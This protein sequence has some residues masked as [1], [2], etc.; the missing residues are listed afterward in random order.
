MNCTFNPGDIQGNILRGYKFGRVRHLLLEVGDRTSA[1]AFLGA[2]AAGGSADVPAITTESGERWRR[3]PGGRKPDAC[4]NLGLTSD[5]LKALG[6]SAA[7]LASFPTEFV[8]GMAQRAEKL[9]DFGDSAPERWAAPFDRQDRIHLVA[10]IHADDATRIDRIQAQVARAFTVLGALDGQTLAENRVF[11]GYIDSI[12]Q[13]RFIGI[14]DPDQADDNELLDPLGTALLGHPTRLEGLMFRVPSPDVLGCNGSFNA[15]RVLAQDCAGFEDYLT[16]AAELL[17]QHPHVDHLLPGD[18]ERQF[19]P[20][21]DRKGALREI[22]AA[23]MCGRW[24]VNGAPLASAPDGPLSAGPEPKG[25]LTN[26]DYA[27]D[28]ACPV[29]AHVRRVNPRGGPIVQR[30]SARTRRVVRR[31]MVYGPPFVPGCHDTAERGLLGS[32]IGASLGAQ[33]EAIMYDWLNLGLQHPDLT[34][35]ND[36]L[37]GANAPETSWFDLRLRN[38]AAIRLRGFP[39]FVTVRGGVYAFLPSLPAIGYLAALG[40]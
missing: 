37:I 30:I 40:T 25:F 12:S 26:F 15:F 9:G 20:G 11:F 21:L 33:F 32:F 7:S 1:R 38:G 10:S 27:R 19:G 8:A 5:G 28:S 34:G 2:A 14:H 24:R 13:P 17:L 16:E 4:F 6:V 22:V 39:R 23:Q 29:G 35:S 18:P 31:G 3:Q 36:P